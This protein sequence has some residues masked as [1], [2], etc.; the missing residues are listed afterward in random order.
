MN[1]ES[2]R[3]IEAVLF[4]LD[5]TFADTAPDLGATLNRLRTVHDLPPVPLAG[6][7]PYTSQGVR[8]MLRAGMGIATDNPRYASLHAQ[9][10]EIYAAHL[11]DDTVL[12]PGMDALVTQIEARGLPWGIVT[13]KT[14]RFT[15][16]LM[17]RLGYRHRAATIVC[18]DS[19]PTPKPS[20]APMLLA[21]REAGVA[22]AGCAFVGDDERDVVAGRA[23]GMMTLAVRYGY[24]GNGAP[25]ENWG[26]DLILDS[27]EE[28][29]AWLARSA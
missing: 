15:L 23:A 5:G 28:I 10:L 8:G 24:L 11:C 16:P 9:Y 17:E 21:A 4:D 1:T 12:F 22:P 2:A 19:T 13:N 18:G 14:T 26:A 3:R 27:V 29:A 7:R 25:I 6:L 20:P